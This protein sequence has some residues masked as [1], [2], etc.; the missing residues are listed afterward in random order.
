MIQLLGQFL[1]VRHILKFILPAI[2]YGASA[3]IGSGDSPGH[4]ANRVGIAAQADGKADRPGEGI[5]LI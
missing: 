5:R 2:W 1:D 4:G 3:K